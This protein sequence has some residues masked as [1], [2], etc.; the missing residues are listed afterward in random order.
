MGLGKALAIE[1]SKRKCKLVLLDVR[2]DL[3]LDLLR[4]VKREGG[5][6]T[7]YR[8]DLSDL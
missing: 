7:F 1:C 5:E 3:S 6:A 2:S 4:D 8:C